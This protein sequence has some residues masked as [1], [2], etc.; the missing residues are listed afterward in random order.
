MWKSNKK[1]SQRRGPSLVGARKYKKNPIAQQAR[2]VGAVGSKGPELKWFDTQSTP[3]ITVNSTA[4]TTPVLL[5]APVRGDDAIDRDGR[6]VTIKSIL[7]RWTAT[8]NA[9]STFGGPLRFC[10]IYDHSPNGAALGVTDV[11]QNNFMQSPMRLDFKDRFILVADIYTQPLSQTGTICDA[12]KVFRK[13]NLQ[14]EFNGNSLGD[15]GDITTG[16]LYLLVSQTGNIGGAAPIF[17]CRT[18][19][20]FQDN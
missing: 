4:W 6:S 18:R 16:G 14:V 5:F 20:R 13:T 17:N 3:T 12:G 2:R 7:M 9:A 1:I 19:V 8:M 11:F 15:I 10:I